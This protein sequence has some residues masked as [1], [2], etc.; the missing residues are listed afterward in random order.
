M[1][2]QIVLVHSVV[3]YSCADF[4]QI[5]R[6]SSSLS[7]L[8]YLLKIEIENSDAGQ[9]YSNVVDR[10]VVYWI[11]MV[12]LYMTLRCIYCKA[13]IDLRLKMP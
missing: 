4:L 13:L 9:Y 11:L 7:M 8:Y 3:V 10:N 2:L 1:P 6:Y 5:A 12:S